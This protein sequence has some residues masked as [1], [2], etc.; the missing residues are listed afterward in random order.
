MTAPPPEDP[1]ERVEAAARALARRVLWEQGNRI[2]L[3]RCHAAVGLVAGAQ[4]L[5]F[6]STTTL[7]VLFGP[8]IRMV[9]GVLGIVG[10]IA[11]FVGVH[12]TPRS[13]VQEATGLFLLGL[14]DLLMTL[15]L[16][17][18]RLHSSTFG[19]RW[20]WTPMPPVNSGYVP[21]Y[22]IAVYGGMFALICI[23]LYTLHTFRKSGAPPAGKDP[24]KEEGE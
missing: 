16:T 6:G 2:G 9:L 13:I 22:P 11:L 17:Y 4:M 23:H 1:F 3:L 10:G 12:A 14:W 24:I 5:A 7:E 21:P 20:P 8:P 19:L 15:G 18:A